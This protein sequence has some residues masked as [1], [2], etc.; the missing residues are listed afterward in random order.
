MAAML[1]CG[2]DHDEEAAMCLFHPPRR[3]FS[4]DSRMG[5]VLLAV[6][7]VAVAGFGALDML[8]AFGEAF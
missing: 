5:L 7:V 2:T 4:D 1:A 6:G 8:G 3:P